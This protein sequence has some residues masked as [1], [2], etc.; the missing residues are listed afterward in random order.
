MKYFDDIQEEV[1]DEVR[2][3]LP[4]FCNK[5]VKISPDANFVF[6]SLNR[7]EAKKNIALAIKAYGACPIFDFRY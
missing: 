2:S 4:K 3:N 7:Y 5:I 1:V 6:L